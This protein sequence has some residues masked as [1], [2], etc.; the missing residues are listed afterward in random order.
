MIKKTKTSCQIPEC[1]AKA[2]KMLREHLPRNDGVSLQT[3][4]YFSTVLCSLHLHSGSARLHWNVA[5]RPLVDQLKQ[6]RYNKDTGGES[7]LGIWDRCRWED[8]WTRK[9]K[10]HGLAV[11][12]MTDL[13]TFKLWR[14]S[15][16]SLYCREG[17]SSSNYEN[18]KWIIFYL[19]AV[20]CEESFKWAGI[21]LILVSK[22]LFP[23]AS[24]FM[25]LLNSFLMP[26]PPNTPFSPFLPFEWNIL[27][28]TLF[29]M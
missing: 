12:L 21:C 29:K 23:P 19:L 13:I 28:C 5:W 25:L 26:Q 11:L 6:C 18:Y 24:V 8:T 2:A 27:Q 9:C 22:E 3:A 4:G 17:K 14:Q 15:R 16:C 7:C 1:K 20:A 10:N